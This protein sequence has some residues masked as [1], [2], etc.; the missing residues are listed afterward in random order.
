MDIKNRSVLKQIGVDL[1]K[2][3]NRCDSSVLE[4]EDFELRTE[5]D[6]YD[7]IRDL[8]NTVDSMVADDEGAESEAKAQKI[9]DDHEMG[10]D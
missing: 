1:E 10:A 3:Q 4:L 2:I 8:K 6:I 5:Y 9:V 7:R